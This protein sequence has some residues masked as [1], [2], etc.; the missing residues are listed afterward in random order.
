MFSDESG[1]LSQKE[2]RFLIFG[3]VSTPDVKILRNV[4]K[5][6]RQQYPKYSKANAHLHAAKNP[7]EITKC[8]LRTLAEQKNVV[9]GVTIFDRSVWLNRESDLDS[10]YQ[11]LLSHA[12]RS[13]LLIQ[14]PGILSGPDVRVVVENRFKNER[15][16]NALLATIANQTGIAIENIHSV[17]KNSS[18]WGPALQVADAIAWSWYQKLAREDDTYV[19]IMESMQIREEVIGMDWK[20][21]IRAVGDIIGE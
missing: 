17:G 12:I 1:D 14:N 6:A 11:R 10:S 19:T 13:S 7:P 16:R 2:D 21:E 20:G 3:V 4:V 15:Q 18:E 8:L 5:K 9:I